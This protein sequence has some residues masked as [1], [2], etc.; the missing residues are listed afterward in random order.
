MQNSTNKILENKFINIDEKDLEIVKDSLLR[1]QLAGTA[2]VVNEYEEQ[3]AKYFNVK[4][5][6][7]VSSG[8][9]ALHLLLFLYNVVP[10]DEVIVPPT[11]PIMSALPILA[12]FAKPVFVEIRDFGKP[13]R[14]TK[15]LKAIKGQYGHLFGLN[16]RITAMSA[17]LGISQIEK[18]NKKIYDRT[19]NADEIK[20]GI[21]EVESLREVFVT[22]GFA[23]NYYS[24]LFFVNDPSL[25][26]YELAEKL[27][28]VGI[29]S[30]TFRF[31]I[32]P[33]YE[34]PIFQE[35]RSACPNAEKIL[36]EIITI[37]THEGLKPEDKKYIVENLTRILKNLN[38][39]ILNIR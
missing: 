38:M 36:K 22:S 1:K 19:R 28:K 24:L 2:T 35:F 33:L 37:P 4:H 16:F 31:G 10:G 9:A 7:A 23:P 3:L 12:L 39:Y 26:A 17:A 30:D 29:I 5:A 8:T 11:A 6:L 20:T 15:Q 27:F 21:K 32:R 25:K 18:I 14:E 34:L 13:V